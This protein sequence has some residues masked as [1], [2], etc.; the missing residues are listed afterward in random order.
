MRSKCIAA[1]AAA[2]L[3]VSPAAAQNIGFRVGIAQPANQPAPAFS[4]N[5]YG[6]YV[7]PAPQVVLPQQ[8]VIAPVQI[9]HP[10]QLVPN[11]LV[12]TPGFATTVLIPNQVLIAPPQVLLPGQTVFS[13]GFVPQQQVISTQF[14][15]R[16]V[17]I[18][19]PRGTPRADVLRQL[20]Q[21]SVSI[22]TLGGE[23]LHFDG[24]LVVIIQNGQVAGPR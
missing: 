23:T 21:P 14:G 2:L 12:V 4:F 16:P 7:Y 8:F 20:G 15:P 18:A 10:I 24:G 5:P 11:P 13:G 9:I 17:R 19:P 1:I 22:I 6:S 3:S